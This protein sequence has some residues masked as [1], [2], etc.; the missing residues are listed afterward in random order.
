[1]A[2][3]IKRCRL[4]TPTELDRL[5]AAVEAK[6]PWWAPWR[7]TEARNAKEAWR[8]ASSKAWD[9]AEKAAH[10]AGRRAGWDAA[11][12]AVE[13]AASDAVHRAG[14]PALD[15]TWALVWTAR[16]AATTDAA[17]A[18][19]VRDLITETQFAALTKAWCDAG[20]PLP[21]KIDTT[22]YGPNSAAVAAFI[23]RC[24]NLTGDEL[25]RLE[26]GAVAT[27]TRAVV[28]SAMR[29]QR[30]PVASADSEAYSAAS[31][32]AWKAARED[33][34]RDASSTAAYEASREAANQAIRRA[35]PP[36]PGRP[37][38]GLAWEPACHAAFAL[39]VADLITET[40]FA[41][42]TKPWRDAGLPMPEETGSNGGQ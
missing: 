23:E 34:A 33:P 42:L 3:L 37:P 15:A 8:A 25:D 22:D 21:A 38:R 32:A 35:P 10:E 26:S 27:E 24:R 36:R 4:L 19:V 1:M 40:E 2:A 20:L 7:A 39:A 18:L 29:G 14:G 5:A 17:L 13:S 9:A 31:A 30:L 11:E 41:N 6:A 16:M 12:K 28:D